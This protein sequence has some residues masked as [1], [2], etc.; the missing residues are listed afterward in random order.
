MITDS[1]S[2]QIKKTFGNADSRINYGPVAFR[3]D[4]TDPIGGNNI[5][6]LFAN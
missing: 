1:H 2:I 3:T 5:G 4:S 6:G